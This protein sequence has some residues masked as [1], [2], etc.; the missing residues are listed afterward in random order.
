MKH[1][2]ILLISI[3][4]I[5]FACPWPAQAAPVNTEN[6]KELNLVFLHGMGGHSDDHQLLSDCITDRLPAL[7]TDYEYGHPDIKVH[8]EIILR[9]YPNDVDIDTWANNI[10]DTLNERFPDK[11]NLVLIGHSMGGKTALYAVAHNIGNIAS[12]VVMVVTINSPIKNLMNYYYIGGDNALGYWGAKLVM[13]NRGVLE[14]LVNYDSSQDGQWVGTHKH[15][16]AF[17]SAESSPISSQFD[18]SGVDALPRNI[19]DTIVP[20]SAQYAE[21][22]DVVYYGEYEHGD[23]TRFTE[24]AGNLAD[25]IL[26][27][28]FG[29]NIECSVFSRAGSFEHQSGI[30]PGTSYWQDLVG[31]VLADSGTLT[32]KNDSFFRWQEW[33]DIVGNYLTGSNR[34]SYQITQNNSSPFFTGI[35]QQRWTGA[36]PQDGRIS[37]NTRAAPRSSVQVNWSVYQQGLLP[38]GIKRDHYE[39]EV[40]TG[41]PLTSIGQVSWETDDQRDVRL[42]IW[43]Q[44]QSPSRWFKAQ[45]RVYFKE[46]RQRKLIDEIPEPKGAE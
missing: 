25:Q 37:L 20:I 29:G 30:F 24:V 39:V 35:E 33:E 36:E 10:V 13:S 34:S 28:I 7:I 4:C 12:R 40:T 6:V 9:S 27:Y 44:A 8:T 16:L 5:I 26:R 1:L 45:W 15:W 43:S 21:G 32:H 22:A 38:P 41:T 23:F 42:R 31:G 19:D 18:V 3:L 2:F 17:V 11:K 14:S 46:S